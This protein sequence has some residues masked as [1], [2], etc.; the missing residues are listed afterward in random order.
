VA[1]RTVR[2][3]LIK[4][5]KRL[6]RPQCRGTFEVSE[7]K[8]RANEGESNE[9]GEAEAVFLSSLLTI[10]DSFFISTEVKR[11]GEISVLV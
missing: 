6:Y 5:P 3:W 2:P 4:G 10:L 8:T 1:E 11:S 9:S 7:P